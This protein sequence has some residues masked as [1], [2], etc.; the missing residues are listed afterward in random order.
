MEWVLLQTDV[1]ERKETYDHTTSTLVEINDLKS[2]IDEHA[3]VAV[4]DSKGKI[5]YVNDKFC[6][7]SKY[8]REELMGQDH[9]IINSGYHPAQFIRSIWQTI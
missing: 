3:I 2:A 5:T 7:I 1:T 4:T 9:R 6:A 8:H